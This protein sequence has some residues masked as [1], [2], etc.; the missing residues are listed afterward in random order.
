MKRSAVLL[1]MFTYALIGAGT[2][3]AQTKE[4]AKN[5]S[6]PRADGS[7][8]ELNK[9]KGKVVIVNFWATWCGPCVREIPDFVELYKQYKDKGLEIVGISIDQGGW[10]VVQPFIKKHGIQYPIVLA[11][12]QFAGEYGNIQAIPT[13]YIVDKNGY[14]V[15]QLLGSRSKSMLEAKL[16]PLFN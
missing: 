10:A 12:P 6:L 4:H 15:E 3:F 2:S 13:T 5:F 16:K 9:L 14:V 1:L 7:I 11:T 8:I